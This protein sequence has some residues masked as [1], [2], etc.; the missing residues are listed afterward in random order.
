MSDHRWPREFFDENG[1]GYMKFW[2]DGAWHDSRNVRQDSSSTSESPQYT[3]PIP[4]RDQTTDSSP[5]YNQGY[6]TSQSYSTGQNQPAHLPAST[7]GYSDTNQGYSGASQDYY[8]QPAPQGWM[9]SMNVD[10]S[11]TQGRA[12]IPSDSDRRDTS[13]ASGSAPIQHQAGYTSSLTGSSQMFEEPEEMDW[14]TSAVRSEAI[15]AS[16]RSGS[17]S[18]SVGSQRRFNFDYQSSMDSNILRCPYK[19]PVVD[20]I[21][22]VSDGS[23]AERTCNAVAEKGIRYCTTHRDG[24]PLL[25]YCQSLLREEQEYTEDSAGNLIGLEPRLKTMVRLPSG[26]FDNPRCGNPM[27][28]EQFYCLSCRP[29]LLN[30]SFQVANP[31][32]RLCDR[33]GQP[34]HDPVH[35]SVWPRVYQNFW[36]CPDHKTRLNQGPYPPAPARRPSSTSYGDPEPSLYMEGAAP[37]Q[38]PPSSRRSGAVRAEYSGGKFTHKSRKSDS[39][40]YTKEQWKEER[41]NEKAENARLEREREHGKRESGQ[42]RK[43]SR[44]Q[45]GEAS[46]RKHR[47]RPSK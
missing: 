26:A 12:S 15:F 6:S 10:T 27:I 38:P 17:G 18:G 2:A 33:V 41:D 42:H 28:T 24:M 40:E 25:M 23:G 7:Q 22:H 36:N 37:L 5:S 44:G 8:A 32:V 14:S 9:S 4:N 20:P 13:Y 35:A 16:R 30:C 21:T 29:G 11:Y 46:T 1:K 47:H 39:T 34:E 31:T 3:R 43:P 19:L 45:G